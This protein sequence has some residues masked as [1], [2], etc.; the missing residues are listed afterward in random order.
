MF[1]YYYFFQ[2]RLYHWVAQV[3]LLAVC[4]VKDGLSDSPC[5]FYPKHWVIHNWYDEGHFQTTHYDKHNGNQQYH[6]H[7][8]N[9]KRSVLVKRSDLQA[10]YCQ[11]TGKHHREDG[12]H[13]ILVY[14]FHVSKLRCILCKYLKTENKG[15]PYIPHKS[16]IWKL[17][18]VR[19]VCLS[20]RFSYMIRNFPSSI[21]LG[22]QNFCDFTFSYII[23]YNWKHFNSCTNCELIIY[24]YVPQQSCDPQCPPVTST[25]IWF[26][27]YKKLGNYQ[28]HL[29]IWRLCMNFN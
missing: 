20:F 13:H 1:F 8:Y 24:L 29:V 6:H 26:W 10:M 2:E 27:F 17:L 9:G 5:F 22:D 7:S 19:L 23:T 16:G 12:R 21:F 4:L 25:H 11:H 18:F 28:M 3:L 15:N 14:N